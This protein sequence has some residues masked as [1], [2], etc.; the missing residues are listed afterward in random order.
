MDSPATPT[1][2]S[3]L[4]SLVTAA[5]TEGTNATS[6]T[7]GTHRCKKQ[8]RTTTNDDRRRAPNG[9]EGS[10]VTGGDGEGAPELPLFHAHPTAT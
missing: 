6:A 4:L 1:D 8:Q 3:P 9:G 2:F 7:R 10:P 5:R